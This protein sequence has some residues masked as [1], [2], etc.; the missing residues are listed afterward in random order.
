MK[1]FFIG[2]GVLVLASLAAIFLLPAPSDNGPNDPDVAGVGTTDIQAIKGAGL[3][4]H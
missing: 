4:T 2:I 3:L 1:Y